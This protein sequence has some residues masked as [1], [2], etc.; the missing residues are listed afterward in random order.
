[1]FAFPIAL[2]G[3]RLDNELVRVALGLRLGL[4][5]S[6]FPIFVVAVR[7]LTPEVF[8][9]LHSPMQARSGRTSRHH[10]LNDMVAC[11]FVS[12][13]VAYAEFGERECHQGIWGT[14]VPQRSLGAKPLIGVWRRS[15]QKLSECCN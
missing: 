15:P 12:T 1:M 3:L 7:W 5:I 2:C 4:N 13:A 6:R 14:E 9:A 11:A 8:I 10:A